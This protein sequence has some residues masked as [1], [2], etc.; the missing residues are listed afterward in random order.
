MVAGCQPVPL[1]GQIQEKPR[2]VPTNLMP[3]KPV[4]V[5]EKLNVRS[6]FKIADT[7]DAAKP[8]T[9]P[10]AKPGAKSGAKSG[11]KTPAIAPNDPAI[12]ERLQEAADKAESAAS[13]QANAQTK[14]DWNLVFDRW[15]KAIALLSGL[16]QKPA[17]V[18]KK[19]A[20]YQSSLAQATQ[21]ASSRLNRSVSNQPIPVGNTGGVGAIVGGDAKKPEPGKPESTNKSTPPPS[22]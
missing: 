11:A 8:V 2:P 22:P 9:K 15:K 1:P 6:G 12:V 4:R 14:D 18:Q 3:N 7:K 17:N 16:P 5:P 13:L 19:L 21:E 20:E 10:G